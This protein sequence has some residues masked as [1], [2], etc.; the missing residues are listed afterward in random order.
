M[1][2]KERKKLYEL[3]VCFHDFILQL[4]L[5]DDEK[6]KVVRK[7]NSSLKG[8]KVGEG[9]M[10]LIRSFDKDDAISNFSQNL[11][12]RKFSKCIEEI[13][14]YKADD[15]FKLWMYPIDKEKIPQYLYAT[16]THPLC[17]DSIDEFVR[18]KINF[19][20]ANEL[21]KGDKIIQEK[22]YLEK[23]YQ[24]LEE[25]NSV[26][27]EKYRES[28]KAVKSLNEEVV[29]LK[30]LVDIE[31]NSMTNCSPEKIC[32]EKQEQFEAERGGYLEKIESLERKLLILQSKIDDKN[33]VINKLLSENEKTFNCDNQSAGGCVLCDK[34][35]L[36]SKKI[37]MVGGIDRLEQNYRDVV[38]ALN[39]EFRHHFGDKNCNC[40]LKNSIRWADAVICP[41]DVNSHCACK[42][43]KKLC[44]KYNKKLLFLKNSG[45]GTFERIVNEISDLI[46]CNH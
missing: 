18:G 35:D 23:Q 17:N 32:E 19:Y 6:L 9:Y 13:A 34:K 33:K 5:G 3:N 1:S 10:V 38:A 37:L 39:G 21:K 36:C 40:E 27:S 7:S 2:E 11:L 22:N 30:T 24:Y 44:K 25:K 16:T 41:I 29:K 31:K 4:C 45:V 15:L 8:I 12:D 46:A 26:V 14:G 20:F 42:N 43:A 28:K